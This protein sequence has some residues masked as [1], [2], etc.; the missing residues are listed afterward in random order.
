MAL[1]TEQ[2]AR[3]KTRDPRSETRDPK[4][5]GPFRLRSS[6]QSPPSATE[7]PLDLRLPHLAAGETKIG[8][9]LALVDLSGLSCPDPGVWPGFLVIQGFT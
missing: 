3:A 7:H 6:S 2:G 8:E 9:S 5:G 1:R 4:R